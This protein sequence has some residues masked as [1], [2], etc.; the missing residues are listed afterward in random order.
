[1]YTNLLGNPFA[2]KDTKLCLGK[3][4]AKRLLDEAQETFPYEYSA[5]LCGRGATITRHIAMPA[6]SPDLHSF[7]W[8]GPAFLQALRQIEESGLQWLGVLHTHPHTPPLPSERDAAGWHYP[9]LSYWIVGM[10]SAVPEWRLYQ[11]KHGQ[12]VQRPYLLADVT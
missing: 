9:T 10:A 5:L 7:S 6:G 12:F 4:V 11:W 8:E 3:K 1:M 2:F